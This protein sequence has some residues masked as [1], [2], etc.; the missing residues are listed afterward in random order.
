MKRKLIVLVSCVLLLGGLAACNADDVN[1]AIEGAAGKVGIEVDSKITQEQID[2]VV[3]KAKKSA[4]TV[5]EVAT[6]E[7][8]QGAVKGLVDSVTNAVKD[9]S[10]SSSESN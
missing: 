1:G 7:E 6:D 2:G 9:V 10:E 4:D 8:V 3:D 5:K